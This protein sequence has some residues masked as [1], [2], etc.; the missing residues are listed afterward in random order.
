MLTQLIQLIYE[1]L[2]GGFIPTLISACCRILERNRR[3]Q[4]M[5]RNPCN[6]SLT[7]HGLRQ[8]MHGV[9]MD[10]WKRSWASEQETPSVIC[11]LIPLSHCR[12]SV[13]TRFYWACPIEDMTDMHAVV[14]TMADLTAVV[15]RFCRCCCCCC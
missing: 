5:P 7:E 1:A 12:W 3:Q 13:C 4:H 6:R 2:M 9:V 11:L 15:D 14:P 8:Q 10:D